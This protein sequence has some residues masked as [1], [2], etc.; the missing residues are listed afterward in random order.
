MDWQQ[1]QPGR[2]VV[3]VIKGRWK[4]DGPQGFL[5]G[6]IDPWRDIQFPVRGKVYTIRD[7]YRARGHLYL[8]LAE[9][10]NP[11]RIPTE[12]GF[13]ACAFRLLDEGR[14]DVFRGELVPNV[15]RVPS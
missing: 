8:L 5:R 11:Q 15:E 13:N 6:L 10:R 4:V 3:C 12:D 2:R 9:I 1:Y 14:L 7:Q